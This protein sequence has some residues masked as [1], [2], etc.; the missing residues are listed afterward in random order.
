M[1]VYD[2]LI[3]GSILNEARLD[4]ELIYAGKRSG[5]HHMKQE[6][7]S[8]LLVEKALE[9]HSVVRLKGGD[10]FIFGRG[11]EEAL[12]LSKMDIPFEIVPGSFL[13]L[14]C[15]CLCRN[16][17]DSPGTGLLLPCDHRP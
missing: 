16:S 17:G 3:S 12:E 13:I 2:N 7:I 15:S 11:G 8:A 14:Q 1:I 10:P 5:S 9:G 6:E 4:A